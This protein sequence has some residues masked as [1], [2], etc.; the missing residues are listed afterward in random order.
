MRIRSTIC[1]LAL[2]SASWSADWLTDGGNVQRTAWQKDEKIFS[3][4][5]VKDTKLLWK[6]KLDNEVRQMHALFPPL[7]VDKVTTSSGPKQI[8]IV[9]GVSDNLFAIDVDKGELLWKKHFVSTW[10]QPQGG[11]GGGILCPGGIT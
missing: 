1:A 10:T 8:A 3:V 4:S 7:I 9:A 11:R 5:T 2:A 6:I